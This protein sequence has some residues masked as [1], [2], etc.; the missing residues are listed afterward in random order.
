MVENGDFEFPVQFQIIYKYLR[1]L[2]PVFY[3]N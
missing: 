3:S 1:N 2:F